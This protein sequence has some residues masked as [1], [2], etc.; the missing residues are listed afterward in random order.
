LH[1]LECMQFLLRFVQ[2]YDLFIC[3]FVDV[4]KICER[5]LYKVYVNLIISYV[6]ANGVFQT[7]LT[8]ANYIYDSLQMAW[9]LKPNFGV[10]YVRF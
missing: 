8:I 10:E 7:F 9:I 5:N 6:H 1:L 2:F 4:I 3:D